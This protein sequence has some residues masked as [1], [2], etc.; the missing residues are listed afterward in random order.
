MTVRRCLHKFQNGKISVEVSGGTG[1]LRTSVTKA[2]IAGVKDDTVREIAAYERIKSSA[3]N[4]ILTEH[5][6]HLRRYVPIG[7]TAC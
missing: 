6:R 1:R 3:R 2:N 4:T 5:L 7:Y